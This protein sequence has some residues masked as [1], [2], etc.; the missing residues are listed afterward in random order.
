MKLNRI[1]SIFLS[2]I[3]ILSINSCLQVFAGDYESFDALANQYSCN[4]FQGSIPTSYHS[5]PSYVSAS[6]INNNSLLVTWG[7]ATPGN[8]VGEIVFYKIT[9][10]QEYMPITVVARSSSISNSVLFDID[11]NVTHWYNVD[12]VGIVYHPDMTYAN[13]DPMNCSA[14]PPGSSETVTFTYQPPVQDIIVVPQNNTVDNGD[15]SQQENSTQEETQSN[16]VLESTSTIPNSST[17]DI[18]Q[19]R[20]DNDNEEQN[21]SLDMVKIA[22]LVGI[23]LCL[24]I[25]IPLGIKFIIARKAKRL[26]SKTKS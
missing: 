7:P 19:E 17:T 25:I 18:S 2:I 20:E 15:S 12:V 26:V 14:T 24:V 13:G 16:L 8:P 3:V 6:N 10:Y 1:V 23:S 4:P 21:S 11:T 5:A 9:L 22:S